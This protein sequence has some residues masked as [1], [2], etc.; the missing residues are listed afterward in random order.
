MT[1]TSEAATVTAVER[2]LR[3]AEQPGRVTAL[4]AT[5]THF[6]RGLKAFQHFPVQIIDIILMPMIF[7]LMFTYVFGGAFAGSTGEYLQ[8]FLPGILVQSVLLMTVYTGTSLNSDITK[9]VFDRFRSLPFWQPATL[10]GSLLGDIV[11]YLIS[12]VATIL[13]GYLIGY[14]GDGGIVGAL[15]AMALLVVFG[16]AVSWIFAAIG[17]VVSQP[18]RVSG[19]SMIAL[20][21]LMFTSNIFVDP[22]TMP[23]WMQV[24]VKINPL[25]H[26]ATASRSLMSGSPD[27][28]SI[29]ITLAISALIV[30]VL[31]PWSVHLY[32]NKNAH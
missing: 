9:G 25:S 31:G 21:P 17:I 27:L 10:A 12:L 18:E 11:R 30:A 4:S 7:L 19:T 26:A 6:W 13:I 32:T 23:G 22:N 15:G 20:Y 28:G 8:Y 1:A 5:I 2:L 3:D 14:R 24:V 16:F 29:G